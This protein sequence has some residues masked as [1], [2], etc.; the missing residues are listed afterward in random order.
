VLAR[1][2]HNA[3]EDLV[4]MSRDDFR[5]CAGEPAGVQQSG[6]W[7]YWSYT[8]GEPAIGSKHTRCVVTVRLKRGYIES[9]DYESPNGNLIG[10]SIPE[11]LDVVGACVPE[12]P[13]D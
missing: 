7:E 13:E 9:I 6:S 1:K 3:R 10:Q 8:S 4:G 2:A 11:C 12:P 5:R